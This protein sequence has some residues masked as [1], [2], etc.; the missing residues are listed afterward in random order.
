MTT[1]AQSRWGR[2]QGWAYRR[3]AFRY[4]QRYL[5]EKGDGKGAAHNSRAQSRAGHRLG[6]EYPDEYRR[7]REQRIAELRQAEEW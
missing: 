5:A 2:A 1:T 4:P 7:L 3:L 6:R